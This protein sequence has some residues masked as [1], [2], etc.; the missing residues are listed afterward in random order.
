MNK[1]ELIKAVA[2]ELGTSAVEAAPFVDAVFNQITQ[3]LVNHEKVSIAK[4]GDFN[5]KE[6]EAG[7]ALNPAKLKQLKDEGVSAE[8]AKAQATVQVAAHYKPKF[9]ASSVLEAAVR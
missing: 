1:K 3:S 4:F 5:P 6:Y 2:G 9:K 8:D 7:T